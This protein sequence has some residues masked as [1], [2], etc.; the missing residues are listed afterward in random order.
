MVLLVA[1]AMVAG[2]KWDSKNVQ[3]IFNI[4]NTDPL[5]LWSGVQGTSFVQKVS[6]IISSP[7]SK[8]LFGLRSMHIN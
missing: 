4:S 8:V 7:L 3:K 5:S 6:Q 2:Y 1:G